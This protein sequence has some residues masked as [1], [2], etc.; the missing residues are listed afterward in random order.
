MGIVA[1]ASLLVAMA[2]WSDPPAWANMIRAIVQ[3][4]EQFTIG[5]GERPRSGCVGP[6]S[7]S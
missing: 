1:A 6:I 4:I 7:G 3:S 5:G 2:M